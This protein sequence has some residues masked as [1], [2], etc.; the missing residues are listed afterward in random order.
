MN[1]H[2]L[3]SIRMQFCNIYSFDADQFLSVGKFEP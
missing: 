1:A 2:T 3:Q